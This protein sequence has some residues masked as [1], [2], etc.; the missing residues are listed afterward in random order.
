M[1]LHSNKILGDITAENDSALLSVFIETPDYKS[2]IEGAGRL[3]VVGRRGTG[4]S[5]IFKK[6]EKQFSTDKLTDLI[7]INPEDTDVIGFRSTVKRF[8]D[9]NKTRAAT[10]IIWKY[11]LILESI[12]KLYKNYKIK[13]LID[14]DAQVLTHVREWQKCDGSTFT[15]ARS[16]YKRIQNINQDIEE[17]IG[18]I[19]SKLS[20]SYLQNFLSTL[21][22]NTRRNIRIL[23]DR[24][25]EGFEADEIGTGMIAG[26]AY[27]TLD[28]DKRIN[29]LNPVLFLRDNIFRALE[30]IDPDYSR[31]LEGEALRLHWDEYQ[32]LNLVAARLKNSFNLQPENSIRIWDRCTANELKGRDGFRKCLQFTLYRPRDLLLLLNQAFSNAS[33]ESRET[34]VPSD[35]ESSAKSI[36]ISRFQDLLKEYN[37]IFPSIEF[38]TKSLTEGNSE[39]TYDELSAIIE[40]AIASSANENIATQQD[41]QILGPAGI[42]R[43][44]YGVGFIGAYDKTSESFVFCHDGSSPNKEFLSNQRLLIHPCYWMALNLNRNILNPNEAELINDE[45]V[46]QITLENDEVRNSRIGGL[47]AELGGITNGHPHQASFEDWC[48]RALKTIFAGHLS[49]IELHP[50]GAGIQRRDIVGTNTSA[51]PTWKRIFQDYSVRHAIFEIK[52]YAEI[53]PNEY[54]QLLSYSTKQYGK[55]SFIITRDDEET[56]KKGGELDWVR[57]MWFQHNLLIIKLTGKTLA[58]WLAKIRRPEKHDVIDKTLSTLLDTYERRYMQMTVNPQ[59]KGARSN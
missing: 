38:I 1:R 6:L 22:S 34:I 4:K 15:K 27:A 23:I 29:Q 42:I 52:N 53:G 50:N 49:N 26:I 3:I 14:A 51:S 48:L 17:E 37:R 43:S 41:V 44:L 59:R 58:K 16:A 12:T 56:L 18:D 19:Q 25:D 46:V 33:R 35:L 11:A 21:L 55:L 32:L 9:F 39:Y 2:L 40:N 45:Y 24:L 31:N 54:R 30:K 28:L 10:R 5:A 47:I 13:S 20:I 36:S 8:V 57:E 7:L